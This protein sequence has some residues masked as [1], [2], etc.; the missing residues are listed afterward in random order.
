M[1]S[2]IH[3]IE[4]VDSAPYVKKIV[5]ISDFLF[6]KAPEYSKT[7][8]Y[9]ILNHKESL[10]YLKEELQDY[11]SMEKVIPILEN[12]IKNS[13]DHVSICQELVKCK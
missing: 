5:H 6:A 2:L 11:D 3:S 4:T 7:I 9:G 10:A 13:K 8:F 12:I 1:Y